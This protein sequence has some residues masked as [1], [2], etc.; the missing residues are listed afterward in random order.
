MTILLCL[1]KV[2]YETRWDS[3]WTNKHQTLFDG[4]IHPL[5]WIS[6]QDLLLL[7]SH[8]LGGKK[9]KSGSTLK[10]VSIMQNIWPRLIVNYWY[11]Y[12]KPLFFLVHANDFRK[13]KL[14][15]YFTFVTMKNCQKCPRIKVNFPQM[16][17]LH[18]N[19]SPRI[20]YMYYT[21]LY[22]TEQIVL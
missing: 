9:Y 5:T 10:N 19:H 1:Y 14:N 7:H 13:F 21:A 11:V 17:V 4:L 15:N 6:Q 2:C 20:H 12:Y 22:C 8:E 16:K 18:M 3:G